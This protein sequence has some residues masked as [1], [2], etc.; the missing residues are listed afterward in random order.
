MQLTEYQAKTVLARYDLPIPRGILIPAPEKVDRA[1]ALLNTNSVMLKAQVLTG[2]RGKAGG[3]LSA[4]DPLAA[5]KAAQKLFDRTVH[6][7]PVYSVLVEE[8]LAIDAEIYVGVATDLGKAMPVLL[9]GRQGGVDVEAQADAVLREE[10]DPWL[11]VKTFQV[12]NLLR[13]AQIPQNLHSKLER[14]LTRLYRLYRECD[15]ELVEINPLVVTPQ[16][17][18]IAADARLLIDDN[19]LFR[20][21]GF[22]SMRVLDDRQARADKA[23]INFQEID[24]DIGI[25]GTG[26]G[27]AMANMDQVKHFGGRPANFMDIGPG[28]HSGGPEVG[29]DLLFERPGLK[30][31]LVS[32]Y[33]A[34]DLA[35]ISQQLV[36]SLNH[37]NDSTLPVVVRLEGRNRESAHNLLRSSPYRHLHLEENF[38]SAARR[39]VDLAYR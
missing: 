19:A 34:G 21:P 35:N 16:R 15:A 9:C 28:L 13:R 39:I 17:D 14:W 26:A 24:G 5:R 11:G 2:G 25:I 33:T 29:L 30:G 4:D 10:I 38:E 36:A 22:Q 8:K 37:H 6:G 3:I 27:M 23:H 20:Q 18:L 1:L 7:L 31:I 12:K 32:G